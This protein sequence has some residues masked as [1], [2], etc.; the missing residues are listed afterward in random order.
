MKAEVLSRCRRDGL[1][2]GGGRVVCAVSGGADSMAMLW[3]LYSLREALGI[4]VSAAHF[5]HCLRGA[6]SDGD[7]AFVRSFCAAHGIE[8][9]VG[10]GDVS[11]FAA[12]SGRSLEDAARI[13]RYEFLESLPCDWLATAHT[14]DDNAETVLLHLLRGSGLRG[15]C[16]IPPVRGK[17]VRPLLGVTRQEVIAFLQVEDIPWREDSTNAGDGCLRNRLRHHV[18]PLLKQEAPD[19]SQKLLRQSELLRG[20]DAFLEEA[21]QALCQ[22]SD[23]PDSYR[24]S[25]LLAAPDALQKR[26]LRLILR[27]CLPQDVSL[28]HIEA[29]QALLR[30]ENP[31]AQLSLP[32]GLTVRRRYDAFTVSSEEPPKLRKTPLLL[33]GV[34]ELPELGLRITCE[35]TEKCEKTENTPFHFAIKYGIISGSQLFARCRESGDALTLKNGHTKSLKRL[36]IDRKIPLVERQRLAVIAAGDMVLAVA[37]LFVN[38]LALAQEGERAA[39]IRIEKEG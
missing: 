30:S 3:C 8:L 32:G 29:L 13:R 25:P 10:R 1:F 16:G 37:G 11:A 22:G 35:F 15:L 18:L 9:T 24:I 27:R 6:E 33:P 31:S 7:E 17:L 39:V 36:F 4:A 34:T 19:L 20:D 21:A 14:A 12:G 5:N 2:S 23:T 28:A 26:A 38:H